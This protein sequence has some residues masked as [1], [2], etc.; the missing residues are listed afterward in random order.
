[1]AA[2]AVLVAAEGIELVVLRAK[3]RVFESTAHK[4]YIALPHNGKI[5]N[6]ISHL[7]V[8]FS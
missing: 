8:A 3:Y 2:L 4:F 5:N 1:M 7:R 6:F